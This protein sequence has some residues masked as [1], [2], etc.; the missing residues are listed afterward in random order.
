MQ[1][2]LKMNI[3]N[4]DSGIVNSQSLPQKDPLER[5]PSYASNAYP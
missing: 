5:G 4:S 3:G 2:R 1:N